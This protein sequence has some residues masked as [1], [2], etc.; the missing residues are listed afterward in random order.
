M[1]GVM[2]VF[3]EISFLALTHADELQ[4]S[5][6]KE[7]AHTRLRRRSPQRRTKNNE[8]QRLL[9]MTKPLRQLRSIITKQ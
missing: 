5:L 4:H 9:K 1:N 3:A 7:T 2:Q 8:E 6:D